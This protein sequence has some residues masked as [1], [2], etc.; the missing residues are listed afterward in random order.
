MSTVKLI[1]SPAIRSNVQNY[2]RL[3][4]RTVRSRYWRSHSLSA[5]TRNVPVSESQSL[6]RY[7]WIR[8]GR[9][10]HFL[11]DRKYPHK[12]DTNIATWIA[13]AAASHCS[14]SDCPY[15]EF[16]FPSQII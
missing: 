7:R 1:H 5:G 2:N 15:V 16:T 11:T 6:P 12:N 14:R 4:S 3:T 13:S 10:S 9:K 8:V